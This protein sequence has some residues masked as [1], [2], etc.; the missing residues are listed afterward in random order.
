[1]RCH[2]STLPDP[3]RDFSGLAQLSAELSDCCRRFREKPDQR[4]LVLTGQGP[5]AFAMTECLESSRVGNS[6]LPSL[7]E[8][9][10]AVERPVL[11]AIGGDALGP[12]LELALACDMTFAAQGAQFALPQIKYG[13]IPWDGGTQR[14][15]RAVGSGKALE[16]VL[17]GESLDAREDFPVLLRISILAI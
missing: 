13:V 9:L 17:T 4:I 1:M 12:G 14:L 8:P 3:P 7:A 5:K 15:L 16:M 6:P 11:A 2:A 10:A